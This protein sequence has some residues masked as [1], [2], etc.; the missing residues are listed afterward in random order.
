MAT[1]FSMIL[2]FLNN[3]DRV[4]PF[5]IS[6]YLQMPFL[7]RRRCRFY[8]EIVDDAFGVLI[9]HV[10]FF[11]FYV[12]E[13]YAMQVY[14]LQ[15][16]FISL[17]L[18]I[19]LLLCILPISHLPVARGGLISIKRRVNKY[20]ALIGHVNLVRDGVSVHFIGFGQIIDPWEMATIIKCG[21]T[22]FSKLIIAKRVV[23]QLKTTVRMASY[24]IDNP[25]YSWLKE[26]GL[27]SQNKGVYCGEWIANGEVNRALDYNKNSV[28]VYE[29]ECIVFLFSSFF[30][31]SLFQIVF[32]LFKVVNIKQIITLI[33]ELSGQGHVVDLKVCHCIEF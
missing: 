14:C 1:E 7:F 31:Y 30:I 16:L 8:K 27:E 5:I 11:K 9:L 28:T 17:M 4:P 19:S 20:W 22:P 33:T 10:L 6:V 26:L 25:K 32:K 21:V 2:N 24:L 3:F 29:V 12:I 23:S 13:T 15:N 18:F